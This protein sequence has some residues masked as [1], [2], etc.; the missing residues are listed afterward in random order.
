MVLVVSYFADNSF[1]QYFS[2]GDATLAFSKP[3]VLS[4]LASWQ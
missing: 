2:A 4:G 3:F 1:C